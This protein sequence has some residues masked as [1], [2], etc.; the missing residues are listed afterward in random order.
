MDTGEGI[1]MTTSQSLILSL[2]IRV[3][4]E[5]PRWNKGE[6]GTWGK[7]TAYRAQRWQA[8]DRGAMLNPTRSLAALEWEEPS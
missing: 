4:L 1:I 7:D 5:F 3:N 2:N 8:Q 6:P